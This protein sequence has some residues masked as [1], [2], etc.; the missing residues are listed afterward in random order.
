VR[1]IN[2]LDTLPVIKNA[3][4]DIANT[5][6]SRNITW[7]LGGSLLLF[8]K[9]YK[10]NVND[11]D[12]IVHSK[13]LKDLKEVISK[14]EIN[15]KE[16]TAKFLTNHFYTFNIK[17]INI[18]IMVGFVVKNEI[19]IFAFREKEIST[20]KICIDG[21]NIYLSSVSEWKKAYTAMNR[22]DKISLLN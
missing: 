22:I 12:I 19:D 13:D 2:S 6:N 8:I 15:E 5:L 21:E 14:Y 3:L 10:T 1:K 18:D 9:G 4:L 16:K 20:S 7:G 11:I 17:S